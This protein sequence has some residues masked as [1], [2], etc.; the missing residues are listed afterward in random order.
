MSNQS[1]THNVN[2]GTSSG[3]TYNDGPKYT[4]CQVE[5]KGWPMPTYM[6][7]GKKSTKKN[8]S[9]RNKTAG[10]LF[11]NALIPFGLFAAQKRTQRR[12]GHGHG[13]AH[14]K[15]SKRVKKKHQKKHQKKHKKH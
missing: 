13:K 9:T 2:T 10:S 7:G 4:G 14:K 1:S 15:T 6:T 3:C 12:H 11:G 5:A 8:K